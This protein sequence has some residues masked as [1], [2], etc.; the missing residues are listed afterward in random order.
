MVMKHGLVDLCKIVHI[1]LHRRWPVKEVKRYRYTQNSS[2]SHEAKSLKFWSL[3][4]F[5]IRFF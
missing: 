2:K 1:H 3:S 4:V 5:V